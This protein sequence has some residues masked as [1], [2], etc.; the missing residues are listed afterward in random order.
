MRAFGDDVSWGFA[1]Y[2]PRSTSGF[3]SLGVFLESGSCAEG[4][5][6]LLAACWLYHFLR[7]V[8]GSVGLRCRTCVVTV[9]GLTVNSSEM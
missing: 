1:E 5:V 8:C 9:M 3:F 6:C 4:V 2:E 7:E